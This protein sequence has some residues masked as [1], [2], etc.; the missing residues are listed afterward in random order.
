MQQYYFPEGWGNGISSRAA[1]LSA[2]NLQLSAAS[3]RQD[4]IVRETRKNNPATRVS[5]KIFLKAKLRIMQGFRQVWSAGILPAVL[6]KK[7]GRMH[8]LPVTRDQIA[9]PA[10]RRANSPID[11]TSFGSVE[12]LSTSA[13]IAEPTTAAS[14]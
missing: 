14:A 2:D 13:T 8:A 12:S 9:P 10:R 1:A 6:T 11:F 7:A 4:F 5:S 3:S